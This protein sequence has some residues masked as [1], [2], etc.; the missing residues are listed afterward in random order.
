MPTCPCCA[1]TWG[2]VRRPA[3]IVDVDLTNL[4]T[5]QLYAHFKTTAPYLD[6]DFHVRQ[7]D[8]PADLRAA[9]VQLRDSKLARG[10]F[11]RRYYLLTD[12]VRMHRTA[13]DAAQTAA[14]VAA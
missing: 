5:V 11:Y 9:F 10:E 12:R 6:A 4:P 2:P 8:L 13:Q 7:P 3:S 1:H 14:Q